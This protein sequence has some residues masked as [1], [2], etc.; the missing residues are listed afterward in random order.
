M[1]PGFQPAQLE[2]PKPGFAS[3]STPAT[4]RASRPIHIKAFFFIIFYSSEKC[5]AH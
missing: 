5:K 3:A 2:I 1:S 4:D